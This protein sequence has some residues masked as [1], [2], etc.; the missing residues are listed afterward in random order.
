MHVCMLMHFSSYGRH[1]ASFNVSFDYKVLTSY[2]TGN[3][4]E[5]ITTLAEVEE[6]AHGS[7][8][9]GLVPQS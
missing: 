8:V 1:G 3:E 6:P 9:T 4:S 2:A 7:V 5:A